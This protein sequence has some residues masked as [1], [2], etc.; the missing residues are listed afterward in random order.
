MKDA[1]NLE[2]QI[3]ID[4]HFA[5]HLESKYQVSHFKLILLSIDKVRCLRASSVGAKKK[6][7][8]IFSWRS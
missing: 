8:D 7:K 1:T 4:L 2:T 3:G 6:V 5:K